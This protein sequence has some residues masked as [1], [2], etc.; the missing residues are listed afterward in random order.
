MKMIGIAYSALLSFTMISC[1]HTSK[2]SG[3]EI[4]SGMFQGNPHENIVMAMGIL[5]SSM[6]T[7]YAETGNFT[8]DYT[9]LAGMERFFSE[10]LKGYPYTIYFSELSYKDLSSFHYSFPSGERAFADESGF[11]ILIIG[12]ADNDDG[13]DLFM[14]NDKGEY[15]CLIDDT[16]GKPW[17]NRTSTGRPLKK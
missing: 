17:I 5:D 7:Y 10:S 12:N 3:T 9:K 11:R 16:G 2:S 4:G 6:I 14:L 13:M 15:G 1:T 8:S